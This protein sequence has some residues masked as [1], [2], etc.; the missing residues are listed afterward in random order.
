MD[1]QIENRD[2]IHAVHHEDLTAKA[3]KLGVD[4]SEVVALRISEEDVIRQAEQSLNLYS[5]TGLRIALIMFVMGCNQAGYG[6][7]WGVI[8]GI[9]SFQSWHDYYGFPNDGPIMGT[10][11]GL[12]QIGIFIGSPFLTFSDVIGRRGVNFIGNLLTIVAA[13]MQG[14]APNIPCLMIGRFILGFGTGLCTAPQYIAEVAPVHLRGRIVGVFGAC[15]QVGSLVMTGVMMA[16]TRWNTEWQWRLAFMLQAIFPLVVCV[17][18]YVVCPE[19]PR[20]Y[21]MKGKTDKAREVIA[22]YQTTNN[23]I[24]D[25]IVGMVIRQIED[26]LEESKAGF[27]AYYDFRTFFTRA[28]G[29]RTLCLAVYSCF[30][31]WNGGGIISYY[32]SPALT[33]IGITATLSQLGINL[34]NTAI[35]FVF[36]LF[37]SYIIDKFRRRTLIFTGITLIVIFE[38]AVTI[39][40]WRYSVS[41]SK[42]TGIL[43]VLWM[44]LYQVS[45]ASTIATMHN[46]YPVEILSLPLRAKGMG[47]YS[48][49][50]GAAGVVNS[51]GISVGIAKIG[52]KIW[53]VYIIYNVIQGIVAYFLFP[54]T[55]QLSL[56]EIDAVFETKGANPVPLSLQIYKA[57]QE[58]KKAAIGA[59]QSG[60][61]VVTAAV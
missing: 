25:P 32:L 41:P 5:K 47:L 59:E 8:G 44:Y 18:I 52:Y 45:S 11:N 58:R 46:L 16:L 13:F 38:T 19:S 12:M 35:Y 28:V 31:Q 56:E 61:Q 30:Q 1:H 21:V 10:I 33:T 24:N 42:T 29:Y 48:M 55:S 34:G 37:G 23:D 26:S 20:Y 4:V 40:S 3:E 51:Y 57:R 15:F 14:N 60:E 7:D 22:K 53:V 39:T 9:N 17:L 27:F 49:I 43:T 54:E 2:D 6:V 36:T 50:Q